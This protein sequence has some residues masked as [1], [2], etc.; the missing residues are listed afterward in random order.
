[1]FVGYCVA[2]VLLSLTACAGSSDSS[3][4]PLRVTDAR[5]N[6]GSQ[7][8]HAYT[9]RGTDRREHTDYQAEHGT[10]RCPDDSFNDCNAD[11]NSNSSH[12]DCKSDNDPTRFAA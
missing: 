12:A 7:R 8:R 3:T 11:R 2:L 10:E 4:P 1:M 5:P 9:Q 6:G